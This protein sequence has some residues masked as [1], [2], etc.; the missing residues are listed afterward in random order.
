MKPKQ[1]KRKTPEFA[2]LKRRQML[3]WRERER[4]D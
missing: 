4:N 3:A 1:D 2:E